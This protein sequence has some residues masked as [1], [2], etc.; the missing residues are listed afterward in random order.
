ME[1]F[2]DIATPEELKGFFGETPT[3]EDIRIHR[4]LSLKNADY[5]F[6]HLYL[7]YCGRGDKEKAKKYLDKIK[8]PKIRRSAALLANEFL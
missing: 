1:N 7:M 6:R 2:F 4:D 8:N 3:P 5:N